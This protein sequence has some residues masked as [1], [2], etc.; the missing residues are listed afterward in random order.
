MKS[1]DLNSDM[2]EGFGA[3][4]MGDDAAMLDIVSSA[5]IACGFHAGDPVIMTSV[6]ARAKAK[7]VGIGAHPSFQD[8]WGFGRRE[9]KG[10]SPA[11]I[12]RMVAYQIG[13]MIG[14]A[15]MAGHQVTHVKAHGSL[16]NMACVDAG[17]AQAIGRAIKAVDPKLIFVVMPL[18][19]LAKAGAALGLTC[20]NEIFADREYEDDGQLVSRK[21]PGAVIHDTDYAVKRAITM[22]EEGAVTAM[23]GKKLKMPID[24]ICVHSDSPDAVAMAKTLRERLT[25]AG[26][27]ITPMHRALA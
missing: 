11:N 25:A 27:A 15:A 17:M 21:K 10:E 7:G 5:N 19:E 23:S 4:K 22:V 12:E 1:I 16:S 3:W 8:L 6:A 9:I 14:C 26:I 13:A 20:A 2:G 18:T 24:T